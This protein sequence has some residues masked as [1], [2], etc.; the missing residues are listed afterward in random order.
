M[1]ALMDCIIVLSACPQDILVI[2]N[3]APGPARG[4]NCW[5]RSP[6]RSGRCRSPEPGIRFG[7]TGHAEAL[8][9]TDE[10]RMKKTVLT[11]IS[12]A[13]LAASFVAVVQPAAAQAKAVPLHTQMV[14]AIN[15]VRRAHHL[16][17]VRESKKL[18]RAASRHSR[19]M[20]KNDYFAHTSPRGSTLNTRVVASGFPGGQ[21][22]QAG[23]TLAWGSGSKASIKHT[24]KAWMH[25][26]E[27]RAILLDPSWRSVGAARAKAS[28]KHSYQ[29]SKGASVWT[30]DFGA[31]R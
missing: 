23:E 11:L 14:K 5:G 9:K 15:K 8:G 6:T 10:V 29:G 17:K 16:H 21:S 25:S 4:S 13:L 2:N 31:R 12:A 20:M 30:A 1:R 22:W 26:R 27:H 19:D 7:G 24:I 3:S 18:R 28:S